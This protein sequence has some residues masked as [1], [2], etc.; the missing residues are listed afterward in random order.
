MI[1]DQQ[2]DSGVYAAVLL[3]HGF[4]ASIATKI[5]ARLQILFIVLNVL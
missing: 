1:R 2:T 4:V 3:C 5:L